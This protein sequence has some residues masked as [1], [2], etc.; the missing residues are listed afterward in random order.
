M[1]LHRKIRTY[2]DNIQ[3][4]IQQENLA[5]T[6]Q[7]SRPASSGT[8]HELWYATLVNLSLY[9]TSCMATVAS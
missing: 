7:T 3:A 6:G 5:A 1:P 9:A 8:P 2:M 4:K